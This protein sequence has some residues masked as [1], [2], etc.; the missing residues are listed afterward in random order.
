MLIYANFH[1]DE[2]GLIEPIMIGEDNFMKFSGVQL[3]E[4]KFMKFSRALKPP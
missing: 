3:G 1:P 4:Y 2:T